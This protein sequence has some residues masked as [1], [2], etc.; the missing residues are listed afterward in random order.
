[1]SRAAGQTH[2]ADEFAAN[3]ARLSGARVNAMLVLKPAFQPRPA[4]VIANRRAARGDGLVE[5]GQDARQRAQ[6][7]RGA[8]DQA[9]SREQ[10]HATVGD[11]LG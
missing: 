2:H 5:R 10:E 9:G 7:P 4:D 1:M 11:A 6:P 8:C 3:E